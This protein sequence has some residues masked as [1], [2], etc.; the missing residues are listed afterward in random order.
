MICAMK[1]KPNISI[2]MIFFAI[3]HMKKSKFGLVI[4]LKSYINIYS[5]Y[6]TVCIH[7]FI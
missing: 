7:T 6:S 4:V 3:I 5:I 2:A 1:K